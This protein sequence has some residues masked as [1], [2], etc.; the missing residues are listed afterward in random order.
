MIK[1]KLSPGTYQMVM[2]GAGLFIMKMVSLIMIP[3]VTRFLA[4]KE[5]GTLEVILTFFN[6][7]SIVI[8][9]G[10]SEAMF[11]YAGLASTEQEQEKVC[12]CAVGFTLILSLIAAI[13]LGIAAPSI[14]TL[15]PGNVSTLQI[16]LIIVVVSLDNIMGVQLGWL[17]LK[18]RVKLFLIFSCSRALLQALFVVI[19]L[20]L[21][22]SVTGVIMAS[23]LSTAIIFSAML[24][25]QWRDT[26][27]HFNFV[28]YKKMAVYGMP[29]ALSGLA[30][31]AIV[32]LNQWWVASQVG[33]TLMAKYA[34]ATKFAMVT[35]ILLY[36]FELWW[37]PRRFT[38]LQETD[39]IATNAR[40]ASMG[41]ALSFIAALFIAIAG[42]AAIKLLTPAVY[43]GACQ[44][45]P[46]LSM[47]WAMKNV[48]DLFNLG[49]FTQ[50][51]THQVL[52]IECTCAV[53]VIIGYYYLIPLWGIA[54]AI[55]AMYAAYLLRFLLFFYC[56]QRILYLPYPLLKLTTIFLLCIFSIYV[57]AQFDSIIGQLTLAIVLSGI[58][59]LIGMALG[60][61]PKIQDVLHVLPAENSGK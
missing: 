35:A 40:I 27:I 7:S 23:V 56:S 24:L 20:A 53:L 55:F 38:L 32:S 8:G 43:H 50:Q 30:S 34:L 6:L 48:A 54:G 9:L 18:N 2:Y 22:F 49:C 10:L 45:L 33:L 12:A 59:T 42:S 47:M 14:A 4:P 51:S 46:W 60:V 17:R 28:E 3:Y 37:Q 39:G 11:R 1:V 31:F 5:F 44:Y 36:P 52:A 57:G 26:G 58:I 41:V 19:L 29:L 25:L 13:F 16:E 15:L 21:G 61:V